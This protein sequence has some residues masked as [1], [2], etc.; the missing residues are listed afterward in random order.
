MKKEEKL[1]IKQ[2]EEL[3]V[4]KFRILGDDSLELVAEFTKYKYKCTEPKNAEEMNHMRIV[5]RDTNDWVFIIV[6]DNRISEEFTGSGLD[7]LLK[8]LI[9]RLF[10][11]GIKYNIIYNE[12]ELPDEVKYEVIKMSRMGKTTGQIKEYL[13]DLCE[14]D[15][16]GKFSW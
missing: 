12:Y 11:M 2:I 9:N 7:N 15:G 16:D 1:L 6:V 3:M 14:G 13:E 10:K 4:S 8:C 5:I